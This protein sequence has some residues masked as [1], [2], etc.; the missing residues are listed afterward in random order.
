[1]KKLLPFLLAAFLPFT[2]RAQ[3]QAITVDPNG[4]GAGTVSTAGIT[5]YYMGA[6]T[7][8]FTGSILVNGTLV[9]SATA[10]YYQVSQANSF[11]AGQPVTINSGGTW[12]GAFANGTLAQA[13]AVGVVSATGL[14]AG[15]FQVVIDGICPIGGSSLT[16]GSIYYVPVSAGIV[17]STAPVTLGQYVYPIATAISSSVLVVGISTPSLISSFTVSLSGNN[18]WTGTNTFN[19]T[20]QTAALTTTAPIMVDTGHTSPS[21]PSSNGDSYVF[22]ST[23]SGLSLYA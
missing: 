14:S 16:V 12:V 19:N 21:A 22:A 4:T 15:A 1:M 9:A 20:V 8:D 23:F 10:V 11:V 17:T 3:R 2:A 18:T 7:Y 13:N 5:Y 6:N